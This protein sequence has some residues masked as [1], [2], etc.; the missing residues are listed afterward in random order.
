MITEFSARAHRFVVDHEADFPGTAGFLS[1]IA[2]A[3][4]LVDS[5]APEY[6]FTFRLNVN[7]ATLG[8]DPDLAFPR[9]VGETEGWLGFIVHS[10]AYR[11]GHFL[12]DVTT[13]LNAA[14]PYR[15]V[16]GARGVTELSAFVYHHTQILASASA[17]P[18]QAPGDVAAAVKGLVT[19]LKAASHF[20]QVTRFNWKALVR[21]DMNEFFTAWGKVDKAVKATTILDY[22]DE[23]PGEEK[24]AARFFYEMLCDYVHPNVGAHTLVVSKAEPLA[25][26]RMRWELTR[27][28]DSDEALSVLF[29]AVAIPVRHAVRFLLHDLEQLQRMQAGF[30][31]WKRR[32]ESVVNNGILH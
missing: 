7:P 28:P 1:A 27:E 6:P 23:M 14:R 30:G 16:S 17:L 15:A 22:I 12:D 5:V 32:C 3:R 31:E 2:D 11:L 9:L 20:A 19:T 13:G 4:K 24:R 25:D 29:H 21:G 26:G 10:V 8:P 18:A